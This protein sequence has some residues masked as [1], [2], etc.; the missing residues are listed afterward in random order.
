MGPMNKSGP[1][2]IDSLSRLLLWA[3]TLP[4]T[5]ANS[6]CISLVGND[7]ILHFAFS[8]IAFYKKFIFL[9]LFDC[10]VCSKIL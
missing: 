7:N 1:S 6:Q 10:P 9:L 2:S 4:E 5:N 8:S 3:P